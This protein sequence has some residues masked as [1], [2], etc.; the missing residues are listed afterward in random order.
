M[1][2]CQCSTVRV[3]LVLVICG[4]VA[5]SYS[6]RVVDYGV[7][8]FRSLCLLLERSLVCFWQFSCVVFCLCLAV[9][10]LSASDAYLDHAPMW[11]T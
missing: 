3:I 11:L 7:K 9:Q 2:C 1:F 6:H 5:I 8:N 10:G 4:D